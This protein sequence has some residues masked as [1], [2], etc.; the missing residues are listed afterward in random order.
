MDLVRQFCFAHGLLG[1]IKSADEVAYQVSGWF[2]FREGRIAC[3]CALMRLTWIWPPRDSSDAAHLCKPQPE[4]R[5]CPLL[6]LLSPWPLR[7]ILGQLISVMPRIRR[8]HRPDHFPASQREPTCGSDPAGRRRRRLNWGTILPFGRKLTHGMLWKDTA[9]SGTRFL[10][11]L[12]L[13][14]PAVIIGLHMGA[15]PWMSQFFMPICDLS[16][17]DCR[18]FQSCRFC[19]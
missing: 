18:R 14:F 5:I 1:S 11:S 15:F 13:M 3:A 8:S 10:I 2:Q 4:N 12:V 16:R 9:A 17:Q 6:G 19:L 7:C